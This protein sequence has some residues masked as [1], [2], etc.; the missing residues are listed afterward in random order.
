MS[1]ILDILDG[2]VNE[3]FNN[4]EELFKKRLEVCKQC[5]L[6]KET[7]VGPICNPKLYI[8]EG[9]DVSTTRKDGYKRGC[10]C[11]LNAKTRL[12]HSRC[13]VGKW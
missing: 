8:S 7:P 1:S 2:H 6:Y 9:G 13:I 12:Q 4:N 5:P 10:S 11:R 3:M